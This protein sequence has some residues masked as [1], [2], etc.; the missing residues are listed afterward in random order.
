MT[1][2]PLILGSLLLLA[3]SLVKAEMVVV[4]H[5]IE[6]RL[7]PQAGTLEVSDTLT[8]PAGRD[9]W[10]F[11]LHAGLAPKIVAGD[12][13]LTAAGRMG[14]LERYR[15][16]LGAPGPVTLTYAGPIRHAREQITE[17]MGRAREW[18]LGSISPEGVFLDGNS[19]WYPRLPETLQTFQLAVSLPPGWTA[20]S[21]GAGP[22]EPARGVSTWTETHPQDYIYLIAGPFERYQAVADGFTAQVYLRQPDEALARRYLDATTTYVELYAALIGPY[23]FAK[24][25]LVENFWETGY[26]MPSFTLL[27]SQVIRLPFIIHTSYPHEILHNWWG[28]SVYVD[29]AT[30]NWSEGLTN[31]LADHLMRER[32]G[33]GWV[34]RRETLKRYADYVAESADFPLSEF[35][36]RHSEASQAIG[37]GKSAMLFHMLRRQLGDATFI[38]G[39]RRFYA[40]NRFTIA[41]FSDLRQAFEAVSGQDLAAFFATWTGRVGAPR[42]HLAEVAVRPKG[43]GFVLTGRIEQTQAGA[44]FSL[45]VP[46]LIHQEQGPPVSRQVRLDGSGADFALELPSAPLRVAVDPWYDVFRVLLP[47]ETPVALSNLFGAERGLILIPAAAPARLQRAYRQLAEAWQGGH[48]GWEIRG[49]HELDQLPADRPVWLLGWESRWLDRFA[50]QAQGFTLDPARR[51]LRLP[52]ADG[53]DGTEVSPVLTTWHQ[54]QPLAWL[55]ASDP[56]AIPGL[57]RKLPHYG[58]Y[59][60]LV[61]TG[62]APDNQI[63]GQWPA[64]DSDLVRWLA[65]RREL[66]PLAEPP[67]LVP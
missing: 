20:V 55:A 38:A 12:A 62:S 36:G 58:K 22:G 9:E 34:Y 13:E 48:P 64:G 66:A 59:S 51:Q 2:S 15:L 5:Q 14:H 67:A 1:K 29:Y 45:H 21:Q 10:L 60:F 4:D 19:A 54:G 31:Y 6:A 63:K 33:E 26:G 43:E 11:L 18:S 27:G 8:L 47:G 24:F 52:G 65:P 56:A 49:D 37:Y 32:A 46:L 23:P 42:L 40:D 16:N 53:L 17:G 50:E 28:N 25:A 7:D 30:G 44:P 35:R 39:L 3:S 41:G 57:A 61:F